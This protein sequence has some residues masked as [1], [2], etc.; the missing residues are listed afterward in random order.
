MGNSLE[1]TLREHPDQVYRIQSALLEGFML[2]VK[3]YRQ[4]K[5]GIVQ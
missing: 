1:Q 4:K 3:T 5:T 2:F